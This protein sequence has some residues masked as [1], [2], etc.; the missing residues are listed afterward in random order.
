MRFTKQA[1]NMLFTL[2]QDLVGSDGRVMHRAGE[3]ITMAV[4]PSDVRT[5]E[6]LDTYL[7]GYS[8]PEFCADLVSKVVL[9]DKSEGITRDL[10]KEN[11]YEVVETAIGALGHINQVDIGSSTGSYK[12]QDQGLASYVRWDTENEATFDVRATTAKMLLEKV[13]LGREVRTWS[14]LTTLGNWN[15][16]NRTSLGAQTYWDTGA[17]KDPLANLRTRIVAS[18]ARV[19][20]IFMNPEVAGWFLQD[21]K[22]IAYM[23]QMLG[24]GAPNPDT[25]AAAAAS[26]AMQTFAIPG[27]PKFTI[28][29]GKRTNATT[30]AMEYILG[31]D[32]VLASVPPGVPRDGSQMAT[33]YS[34]RVKGPSGTGIV[35]NEYIPQDK[36]LYKGIMLETGFS[37]DIKMASTTAGGLIKDVLS[38]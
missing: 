1:Q 6:E 10:S 36:G 12:T 31:D 34:F 29:P 28:V 37:E 27:F 20:D 30:G 15:A 9:V 24:D 16:A 33:S 13:L 25:A 32:V 38:T 23:R 22:V 4:A 3:K 11:T 19:T 21:A 14:K 8:N 5:T 2:A 26:Q 7:G 35:N 17:S 18:L